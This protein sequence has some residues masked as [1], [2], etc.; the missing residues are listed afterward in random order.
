MKKIIS[1]LYAL[2]SIVMLFACQKEEWETYQD[3]NNEF[4]LDIS[5]T[6]L[7]DQFTVSSRGNDV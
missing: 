1:Y 5:T 7:M 4:S 2:L 3:S 6:G